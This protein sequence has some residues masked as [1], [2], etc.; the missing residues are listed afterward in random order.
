MKG[1]SLS[2]VWKTENRGRKRLL[3]KKVG[4]TEERSRMECGGGRTGRVGI[5]IVWSK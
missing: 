2:K 5:G 4:R 3:L 1:Y